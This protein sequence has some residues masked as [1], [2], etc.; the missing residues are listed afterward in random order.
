MS[1]D[2]QEKV[3]Q[4]MSN[5]KR[6]LIKEELHSLFFALIFGTNLA[7]VILNPFTFF[8]LINV[9]LCV[10]MM[11]KFRPTVKKQFI[12]AKH[13]NFLKDSMKEKVWTPKD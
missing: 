3:K 13:I 5:A 2:F 10:W 11:K 1:S 12:L 4:E 9:G 6:I 8:S 7:A